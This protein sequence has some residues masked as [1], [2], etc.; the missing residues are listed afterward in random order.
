M[1]PP[2]PSSRESSVLAHSISWLLWCSN[3]G[4]T[5]K[6]QDGRRLNSRKKKREKKMGKKKEEWLFKKWMY[7]CVYGGSESITENHNLYVT[8]FSQH[9]T[10]Y[11]VNLEKL[12]EIDK[13]LP[14]IFKKNQWNHFWKTLSETLLYKIKLKFG[15]GSK[16]SVPSASLLE[17]TVWN[18]VRNA[19]SVGVYTINF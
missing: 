2:L 14:T 8:W 7:R 13:W 16:I 12:S 11:I 3:Q 10:L 17:K 15:R 6:N 5:W 1:F 19:S 9:R 18:P 4:K